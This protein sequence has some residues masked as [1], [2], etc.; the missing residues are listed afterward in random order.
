MVNQLGRLA[1]LQQDGGVLFV[2]AQQLELLR[3]RVADKQKACFRRPFTSGVAP[4]GR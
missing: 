2:I 4:L 3:G 1:V